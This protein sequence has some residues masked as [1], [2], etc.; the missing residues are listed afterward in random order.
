MID[1]EKIIEA[2]KKHLLDNV[3]CCDYEDL[4]YLEAQSVD[5][6]LEKLRETIEW[7]NS[8]EIN[9]LVYPSKN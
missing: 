4:D 6:E 9:P 2:R 7:I 8:L 5:K 3:W 1:T